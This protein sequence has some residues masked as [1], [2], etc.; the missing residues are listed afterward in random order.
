MWTL[1]ECPTTEVTSAVTAQSATAP[2][3]KPARAWRV[4][5]RRVVCPTSRTSHR[6]ASSSP[7]RS[8]VPAKRPHTAPTMLRIPR[9]LHAVKP[10]TVWI[11]CAG[12]MSAS[13]AAFVPK[14]AARWFRSA[15]VL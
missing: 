2:A 13:M 12:P 6:P 7:R 9:L 8:L 3:A 5:P 4:A 1:E 15:S 14:V 10:A 11:R